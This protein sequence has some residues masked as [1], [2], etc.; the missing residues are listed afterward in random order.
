MAVE[1]DH[2]LETF[3][4]LVGK[5]PTH[6]DSHQHAHLREPVR[7][8]VIEAARKLAVP[9][10]HYSPEIRYCGD[11]YG[12]TAEGAPFA[13]GISVNPLITILSS[14]PPGITGL[15]CHPGE[16]SDL[17][18]MYL[19]EREEEVKVLCHPMIREAIVEREI[20]LCSFASVVAH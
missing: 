16:G 5:A 2:Q 19:S 17:N 18:T 9:L 1:V 14:L 10:R 12:Q 13:D 20:E 15:S 4:L 8:I 7:S 6:I 11:F 3:H